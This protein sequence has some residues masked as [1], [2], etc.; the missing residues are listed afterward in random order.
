V[1]PFFPRLLRV[2]ETEPLTL[3]EHR[4]ILKCVEAHDEDGAVKALTAHL[5]RTNPL[6]SARGKR[7]R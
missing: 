3:E 4:A 2:P 6:Y 7:R 1:F 5:R